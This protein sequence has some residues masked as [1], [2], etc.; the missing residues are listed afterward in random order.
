MSNVPSL[1]GSPGNSLVRPFMA[2]S[3]S[4]STAR[5]GERDKKDLQPR[6]AVAVAVI[7][8][9][10]FIAPATRGATL[11]LVGEA[12]RLEELLFSGGEGKCSPAISTLDRL[13]LK[14]LDDFLFYEF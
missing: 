1:N 13:V 7:I 3:V 8:T 10:G 14:H 5:L 4:L 6:G 12:F 11:G 9:S 2:Q